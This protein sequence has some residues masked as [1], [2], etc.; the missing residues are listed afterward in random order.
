MRLFIAVDLP[1]SIKEELRN[2]QKEFK[3]LGKFYFVKDF[4]LTL[5]FL[6]EVDEDK[7][8]EIKDRLKNIKLDGFNLILEGLGSF[9]NENYVKVLW[10]G[11]PNNEIIELHNKIDEHLKDLFPLD[12]RFK[13]HITLARAKFIGNKD[14]LKEKLKTKYCNSFKVDKF[15]LIKSELTREG[16]VY[17][18]LEEFS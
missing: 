11:C 8:K 2:L 10:V 16:A 3:G 12:Y 6:G 1:E 17:S 7:V 4:H 5:K 15:K 14:K 18:V 9:P 13:G